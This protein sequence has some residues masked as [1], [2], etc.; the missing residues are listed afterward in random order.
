MK[1]PLPQL[2]HWA[3]LK[4]G[5]KIPIKPLSAE[6]EGKDEITLCQRTEPIGKTNREFRNRVDEI[7]K[8]LGDALIVPEK[9]NNPDKLV[10][11]A[12]KS[13]TLR[14]GKGSS[15]DSLLNS[16]GKFNIEVS[17]KNVDR[18]LRIADTFI[19]ALQ[20]RNHE[21]V[22]E[23]GSTFVE[24]LDQKVGLSFNEKLNQEVNPN[25]LDSFSSS[26]SL[27][28][29]SILVLTTGRK[30]WEDGK[31][32]LEQRIPE[33]VAKCELEGERI[34]AEQLEL[35]KRNKERKEHE[36]I[37]EALDKRQAEELTKFK[38]LFFRAH[39]WKQ[40]I[41]IRDFINDIGKHAESNDSSN[42]EIKEWIKWATDKADWYDPTINKDD[43][44]LKHIN[45]NTLF[46]EQS[47][48]W[49]FSGSRNE[50]EFWKPW[51]MH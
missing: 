23:H 16:L 40:T 31:D 15:N 4:H 11:D 14:M 36:R 13:P 47:N 44:F 6:Y 25:K 28:P 45:K 35:E 18:A 34:K 42:T 29:S 48:S 12:A 46:I 3:K 50:K 49:L 19:K 33:M 24:I 17:S 1:I 7:T 51:Y 8:Q 21:I 22:V 27:V 43:E 30:K 32:L 5:R 41:I 39:R 38:E 20:S 26:V 2:G 10:L 9:L 37:Q